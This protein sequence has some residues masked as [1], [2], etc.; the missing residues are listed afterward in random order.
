MNK[1]TDRTLFLLLSPC[2]VYVCPSVCLS[3]NLYFKRFAIQSE[4]KAYNKN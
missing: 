4:L 3:G 1:D 2:V